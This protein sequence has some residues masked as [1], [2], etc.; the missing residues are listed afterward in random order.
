MPSESTLLARCGWAARGVALCVV[1]LRPD[2]TPRAV[3][4][5]PISNWRAA[6]ITGLCCALA[7]LPTTRCLDMMVLGTSQAQRGNK[8]LR[9]ACGFTH[10]RPICDLWDQEG[11]HPCNYPMA[12]M[13]TNQSGGAHLNREQRAPRDPHRRCST[14]SPQ[15]TGRLSAVPPRLDCALPRTPH[16][17]IGQKRRENEAYDERQT[18]CITRKWCQR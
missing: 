9:K 5:Q 6:P 1:L 11:R 18:M 10:L 12:D 13:K 3:L 14:A 4:S 17:A 16:H 2:S 15:S 8:C 7:R